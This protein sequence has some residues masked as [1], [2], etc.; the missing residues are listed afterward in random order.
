[1][2]DRRRYPAND[3]VAHDSLRG[4]AEGVEF[5]AGSPAGVAVPVA[6]LRDAPAGSLLRQVIYGQEVTVLETRDGWSFVRTRYDGYVG[7]V[8]A[9]D[10]GPWRETTHRVTARATHL[11]E[12]AHFKR[13]VRDT[14]SF[15]SGLYVTG[16]SGAFADTPGGF[17]PR[18]HIA[19]PDAAGADPVAVAVLLLGTPY[20]WGGNSSFGIDCSGLVQIACA[21]CGLICPGDSDMQEAELGTSLPEDTP[22][23]RG[24]LLFWRGHVAW[25]ETPDTILHANVH[26]MAVAREPLQAAI[27][28]IADQG[29]GPVTTRKRLGG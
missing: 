9:Q 21:A 2:T 22:L 16:Q 13:P 18:A 27:A 4:R 29:D 25:V 24:D 14:L 5:V 23:A 12:A 8:A 6:D 7:Y 19:K 1:M 10:L 20:L 28:R 11:Y 17:V 15:G 26:H 3:R